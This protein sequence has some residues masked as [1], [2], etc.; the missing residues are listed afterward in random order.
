MAR[1]QTYRS[2]LQRAQEPAPVTV[3]FVE[4]SELRAQRPRP[5]RS[6]DTTER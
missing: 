3:R 1:K 5:Q 6:P 2:Q 4:P